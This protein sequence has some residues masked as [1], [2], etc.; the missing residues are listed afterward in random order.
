MCCLWLNMMQFQLEVSKKLTH[1]CGCRLHVHTKTTSTQR[2]E[3]DGRG[4]VALPATLPVRW[5]TLFPPYTHTHRH[6]ALWLEHLLPTLLC[7]MHSQRFKHRYCTVYEQPRSQ[8]YVVISCSATHR[9]STVNAHVFPIPAGLNHY[10]LFKGP[11][12]TVLSKGL[13]CSMTQDFN[14]TLMIQLVPPLLS[15]MVE[16]GCQAARDIN[17]ISIV[18]LTAQSH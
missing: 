5:H 1:N 7:C 11:N 17:S 16:S 4:T 3:S 15:F 18:S 10:S 9:H 13:R 12:D 8:T 2:C 14:F 6:A